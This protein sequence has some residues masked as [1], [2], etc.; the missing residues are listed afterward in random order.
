M[1]SVGRLGS[2]PE[3]VS[4]LL[5]IFEEH[6]LLQSANGAVAADF[7]GDGLDDIFVTHIGASR[8]ADKP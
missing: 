2:T 6:G 3:A 5:G 4:E 8:V 1:T 7:N